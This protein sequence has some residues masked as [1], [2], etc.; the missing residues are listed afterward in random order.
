[1]AITVVYY[2]TRSQLK[3][4]R[5]NEKETKRNTMKNNEHVTKMSQFTFWCRC[6][7]RYIQ[8]IA[9]VPWD[10]VSH[11]L[12][13][14]WPIALAR[15]YQ[16]HILIPTKS[17]ITYQL[18]KCSINSYINH[19]RPTPRNGPNISAT[20]SGDFLFTYGN[21][22]IF[23]FGFFWLKWAIHS[24]HSIHDGRQGSPWSVGF[25]LDREALCMVR[26]NPSDSCGHCGDCGD[27]VQSCRGE[28]MS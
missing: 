28:T 3:K 21:Y 26:N 19:H 16:L 1:M 13:N 12:L 6:R 4:M 27:L 7:L 18:Y 20:Y 25:A 17:N 23:K 22:T 15:H 11:D 24:I 5:N 10:A 8:I 14:A 9:Q 2:C